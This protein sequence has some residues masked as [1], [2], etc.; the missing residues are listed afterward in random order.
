MS[1]YTG[2]EIKC[3]VKK[4]KPPLG[5]MPELIWKEIKL[6][7]LLRA[8][9]EYTNSGLLVRHEWIDEFE[10]LNNELYSEGKSVKES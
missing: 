5:V 1:E 9:T 7:E 8:I 2:I 3:E 4:R 10:R 6:Q